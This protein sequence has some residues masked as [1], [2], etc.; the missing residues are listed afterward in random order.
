MLNLCEVQKEQYIYQG[1][2]LL[3]IIYAQTARGSP[4]ADNPVGLRPRV[5]S[6]LIR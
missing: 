3:S 5:V 4:Q 1:N 2:E 6:Y